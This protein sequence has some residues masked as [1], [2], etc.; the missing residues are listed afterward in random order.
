MTVRRTA[1]ATAV[2]AATAALVTSCSAGKP[3]PTADEP[4]TRPVATP[5]SG[6][7][8]STWPE[9]S[10]TAGPAKGLSLPMN[11]AHKTLNG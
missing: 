11:S 6:V 3:R 8:K 2:A 10:P 9:A 1:A 5:S 4:Q 7:D